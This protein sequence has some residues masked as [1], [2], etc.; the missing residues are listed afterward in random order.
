MPDTIRLYGAKTCEDTV[1]ARALLVAHNVPY[2]WIDVDE[3][4][5]GL[6]LIKSVNNGK[7]TTPTIFFPDGAIL[8][9]PTDA[10]LAKNLGL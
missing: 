3:D 4:P 1:R 5:E 2:Q 7:R 10:Q 6:A 9:E 8:F